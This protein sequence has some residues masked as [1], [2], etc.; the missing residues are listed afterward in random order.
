MYKR[1]T[2]ICVQ[3]LY[4]IITVHI[5]ISCQNNNIFTRHKFN[6]CL[7]GLLFFSFPSFY[8]L[9]FCSFRHSLTPLQCCVCIVQV[10]Q[11]YRLLLYNKHYFYGFFK[12]LLFDLFRPHRP[13]PPPRANTWT[14]IVFFFLPHLFLSFLRFAGD[15][16]GQKKKRSK[17]CKVWTGKWNDEVTLKFLE[18]FH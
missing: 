5:S 3:L 2:C 9:F 10:V 6:R 13:L 7:L 17:V 1:T 16:N 11:M 12:Y 15:G 4:K 14:F 8:F 18:K